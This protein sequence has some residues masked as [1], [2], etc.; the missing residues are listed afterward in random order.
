MTSH[1]KDIYLFCPYRCMHLTKS[2]EWPAWLLGWCV[3]LLMRD[4][5]PGLSGVEGMWGSP[6]S[7]HNS[8]RDTKC[9]SDS[10][11]QA[12]SVEKRFCNS[13]R[14][15]CGRYRECD[16]SV[17]G[18]W[19]RAHHLGHDEGW[20]LDLKGQW[21]FWLLTWTSRA[22]SKLRPIHFQI[23]KNREILGVGCKL[24]P[25]WKIRWTMN[26]GA[27][28]SRKW[29]LAFLFLTFVGNGFCILLPFS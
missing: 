26:D 14:P 5:V 28:E 19:T 18:V 22:Q 23:S 29:W 15:H 10:D 21:M 4:S 24:V 1:L 11:G 17:R 7:T 12:V 3:Y 16:Q 13:W 6:Q 20:F 25:R 2:N 8:W 27:A 9:W